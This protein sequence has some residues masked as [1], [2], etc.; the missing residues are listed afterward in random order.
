MCRQPAPGLPPF[1]PILCATS[2]AR[3]QKLL[4]VQC[5]GS[6]WI[7]SLTPVSG[8]PCMTMLRTFSPSPA[9]S[10][11]HQGDTGELSETGVVLFTTRKGALAIHDR[12]HLHHHRLSQ[13]R[14]ISNSA[15]AE[16]YSRGALYFLTKFATAKFFRELKYHNDRY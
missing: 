6:C 4:R 10:R 5:R 3:H 12:R 8:G 9:S 2:T 1:S 15:R 14:G 13:R 11:I 16:R 7:A